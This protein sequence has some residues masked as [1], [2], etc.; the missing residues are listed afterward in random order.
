M[1]DLFIR[2]ILGFIISGGIGWLAYRKSAL[3]K[4]GVAGAMITG[5]VIFGFGGWTWGLLLITFFVA[6]SLLSKYKSRLKE[7]LAEKFDKGS[8]RDLWQAFAN[9][10]A[11][12]LL[13]LG[14]G[15]RPHP[16]LFCAFVGAMATV[17][18]DTWATELGVLSRKPPRLITTGKP[19]ERGTSGGVSF[20]GTLAT[21]SGGALIGLAAMLFSILETS[22]RRA[23]TPSPLLLGPYSL[24]LTSYSLLFV[25]AFSGLA[26]SL[27]DSLLGATVQAIYYSPVRQKETEKVI[28]P[29][30][31]PN[32]LLRGWRWLNNDWVNFVS[33]AFG[34][35]VGALLWS[36]I[37]N[38]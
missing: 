6:S 4:S 8:R 3:S 10:G 37:G 26:G 16:A 34:A 30:G 25:G 2:L 12:A 17:N 20:P 18:A 9:G 14:Y 32:Q 28:D 11:G 21:L 38:R 7:S 19:V 27:A 29:D 13:A 35:L 33:S 24:L 15:L 31:T 5:T 23:L 1:M 36:I 22:I